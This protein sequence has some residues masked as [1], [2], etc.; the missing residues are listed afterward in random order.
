MKQ[1]AQ[2]KQLHGD[3]CVC[4]FTEW[5]EKDSRGSI[6]EQGVNK[7]FIMIIAIQEATVVVVLA[8]REDQNVI[9]I[10]NGSHNTLSGIVILI[11]SPDFII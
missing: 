3:H 4:L 8:R 10:R 5:E 1:W 9:V 11:E 2:W 7:S 6:G